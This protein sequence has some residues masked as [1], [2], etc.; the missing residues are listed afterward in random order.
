[1]ILTTHILSGAALGASVK[2]PYAVAGLAVILHFLLD[3]LP[4]GDYLNKKSRPWEFWKVI[5]DFVIGLLLV[6]ATIPIQI[7]ASGSVLPTFNI[8]IGI[9]FSLLPDF[10][11]FLYS[12]VKMHFLKPI[13]VFH[14]SIHYYPNGSPQREFCLKNNLWDI[15]VSLLSISLLLTP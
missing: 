11:T 6:A 5:L 15:L 8:L 10:T 14:E 12:G 2:N 3:L 13:K 7:D 4:H 1:M 9:L